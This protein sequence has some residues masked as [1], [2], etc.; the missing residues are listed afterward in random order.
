M[1]PKTL[2]YS[3]PLLARFVVINVTSNP[4][5]I[6]TPQTLAAANL[7]PPQPLLQAKRRPLEHNDLGKNNVFTLHLRL[8]G[9]FGET[10][11]VRDPES[12]LP[13]LPQRFGGAHK[14]AHVLHLLLHPDRAH[15]LGG[16]T[17]VHHLPIPPRDEQTAVGRDAYEWAD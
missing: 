3:K 16:G 11:G 9:L 1:T 15:R 8:A 12:G 14:A 2:E 10:P 5:S 17:A 6:S 7:S 4:P 13:A